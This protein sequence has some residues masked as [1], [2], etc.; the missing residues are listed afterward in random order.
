MS[1]TTIFH[2]SFLRLGALQ[3]KPEVVHGGHSKTPYW[4]YLLFSL[5]MWPAQEKGKFPVQ[6][7][8]CAKTECRARVPSRQLIQKHSGDENVC[9]CSLNTCSR[10]GRRQLRRRTAQTK[11]DLQVFLIA[12]E[13]AQAYER[14]MPACAYANPA[15]H[16]CPLVSRELGE[17]PLSSLW[18]KS[19][20]ALSMVLQWAGHWM[21]LHCQRVFVR[22]Q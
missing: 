11:Q 22:V 17:E 21:Q 19:H 4:Q 12:S 8:S 7:T 13:C 10:A 3:Q 1:A 9:D 15:Q 2:S 16:T 20:M 18:P 5:S 6:Q 14:R